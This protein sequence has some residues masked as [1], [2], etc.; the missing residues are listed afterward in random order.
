MRIDTTTPGTPPVTLDNLKLHL[1]MNDTAAD[2]LLTEWLAT[3]VEML[4]DATGFVPTVT[5]FTATLTEWPDDNTFTIPRRPLGTVTAVTFTDT[6]GNDADLEFTVQYATGKITITSDRPS[7]T[8]DKITVDFSAGDTCPARFKTVTKLLSA[9]LYANRE[10]YTTDDLK[11][12]P[13]GLCYVVQQLR[14]SLGVGQ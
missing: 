12:V 6:D 10:A 1:T 8:L 7:A 2:D 13:V 4:V 14:G 5:G 11:E 9:H 3:A